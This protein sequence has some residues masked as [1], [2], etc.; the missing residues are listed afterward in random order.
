MST[1][2]TFDWPSDPFDEYDFEENQ[3]DEDDERRDADDLRIQFAFDAEHTQQVHLST[4]GLWE[5]G[6]PELSLWLPHQD[7]PPDAD[8]DGRTVRLILLLSRGM[9]SLAQALTY[10]DDFEIQ[11]YQ[12]DFDG[13]PVT[14]RLGPAVPADGPLALLMGPGVDTVFPVQCSLWPPRPDG[15]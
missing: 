5:L 11:P 2:K 14:L 12:E 1:G 10:T 6:V 8:P 3:F 13:D 15:R 4:E 7:E 9:L